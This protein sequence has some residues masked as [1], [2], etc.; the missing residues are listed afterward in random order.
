[1]KI[2]ASI[3]QKLVC[4]RTR[5]KLEQ[6]GEYLQSVVHSDIRYPIVDDIPILINEEN[7]IFSIED[8]V[9]K[10]STTFDLNE[11]R[12]MKAIKKF[13]PSIGVNIKGKENYITIATML[14]E[15]SKILVIGGSVRGQGMESIYSSESF[16][17]IGSDVSF[18]PETKMICDAHDIPFE[19]EVFDCV[20]VQAV[21]EHV[22]DPQQ[23]VSEIFRV[24]RR[25]GIVY[26]ET[27]FMQ[28]Y[29]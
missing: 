12:F 13:M 17:I 26:A 4:P 22:I 11:N 24:M 6:T 20:I 5:T 21:L 10:R 9:D 8:F 1:M 2:S 7:S 16:E 14:P 23:C 15:D 25:S 27:P 3:Q 19:D 29:I 28:K 18:G